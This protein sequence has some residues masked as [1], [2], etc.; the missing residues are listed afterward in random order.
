MKQA[1]KSFQAAVLIANGQNSV[2]GVNVAKVAAEVF[3]LEKELLKDQLEMGED[4]VLE[5]LTK[6][7]NAIPMN[8]HVG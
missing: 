4:L 3:N 2:I 7:A 6:D 8:V 1:L 5:T